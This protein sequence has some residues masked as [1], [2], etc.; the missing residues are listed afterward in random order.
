MLLARKLPKVCKIACLEPEQST[1]KEIPSCSLKE[2]AI[3]L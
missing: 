2:S 1:L 3:E